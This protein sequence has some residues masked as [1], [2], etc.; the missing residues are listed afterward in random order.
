MCLSEYT[1]SI[2]GFFSFSTIKCVVWVTQKNFTH[3]SFIWGLSGDLQLNWT[4]HQIHF[5]C[6][7][8]LKQ[9]LPEF[10]DILHYPHLSAH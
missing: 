4:F 8:S 3:L 9:H 7:E 6:V 1:K 2:L 5:C 10:S